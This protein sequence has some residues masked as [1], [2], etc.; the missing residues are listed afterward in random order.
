MKILHINSYFAA[1]SFYKN[2]FDSL[3]ALGIE[4]TVYIPVPRGC[5]PKFDTGSYSVVSE[6]HGRYDRI[7]FPLKHSKIWRDAKERF[8]NERFDLIS[9]HSLFSNGYIAYRMNI[10]YGIPYA[11]AV[12]NTDI[13]DFFAKMPHMRPLGIKILESAKRII[14][15]SEPYRKALLSDYVPERL[16]ADFEKKSVVITNGIDSLW[17]DNKAVHTRDA[18]RKTINIVYAGVIDKNKNPE[19]TVA[20]CGNLMSKGY[21]VSFTGI[22]DIKDDGVSGRILQ[23]SFAELPGRK[24]KREL[25]DFYKTRDIFVMPSVHETFGLVYAEA[26]S[27][28]LP[29]I[30]T[31][32]QGFDGIFSDGEVGY[33]VD[34]FDSKMIASRIVDI[35]SDYNEISA[36]ASE[37]SERFSWNTIA[38][39]YEELYKQICR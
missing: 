29:V 26:M 2:L 18:G 28:G 34:P 14:F 21:S 24:T 3:T 22:G 39:K 9:A 6:N 33:A 5:S 25:I 32:G 12:R 8:G 30:Y 19:T 35:L 37:Y 7:I 16:K 13:N 20:A 10:E 1:S 17:L 38:K 36:R 15:I 27:Q 4:N 11:V 31:K 23:R